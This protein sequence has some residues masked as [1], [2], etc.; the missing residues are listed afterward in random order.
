MVDG[1][2]MCSCCRLTVGGEVKYACIDE[3]E[4]DGHRVDFNEA[5]SRSRMY[6]EI[7]DEHTCRLR[8][9]L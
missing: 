9:S 8:R 1:T 2:G 7:E 5:V 4:F 6:K 3:T